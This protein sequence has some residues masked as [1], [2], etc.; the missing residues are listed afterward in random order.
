[1]ADHSTSK[2]SISN[3]AFSYLDQ[4]HDAVF[5]IGEDMRLRLVN[6]TLAQWMNEKHLTPGGSVLS[7][8]IG[9]SKSIDLFVHKCE[10][11]FTGTPVRFEC[12]IRPQ[13]SMPRWTEISLNRVTLNH[14]DMEIIAIA[15]DIS[16]N[17][18]EIAKLRHQANHDE[19]TGL[20]N[21][22]EFTRKLSLLASNPQTGHTLLYL[23]L[24]QFKIINDTCGHHAGDELLGRLARL[25]A[26]TLNGN[27]ILSRIGS[28]EFAILLEGI[29]LEN[30]QKIAK[31]VRDAVAGFRFHWEEKY[32]DMSISIGVASIKVD[33]E[34]VDCVLSAADAACHVAK[35]KGRNQIHVYSDSTECASL[36]R[37]TAWISRITEA[38]ENN[39]FRLFYQNILPIGSEYGCFNHREILLRMIDTDGREIT[40]GEFVPAAEKYHLMPL[41]DRWVI[42]TLFFRNAALWR[43]ASV[44]LENCEKDAMP[45]C[46]INISG[47]SLN[48]DYFPI[49]LRDQLN[50][51]Q[52]PPQA[53]CF[54]ITETVAI[55]NLDK[56]SSLIKEL[57]TLGF[58]F[59]LDDFGSGMSSF[60][61]LKSLPVD[62]LKIDGSLVKNLDNDKT[63]FCMVEAINKIAQE[64]GI[65]TIAEFV[66]NRSI[67]EKLQSIGVNFAQGYSI[68]EPE[69]LH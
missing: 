35:N 64:M 69:H 59:S 56:V 3:P 66:G 43:S 53:V 60:A 37:E 27:G 16:A 57:K 23:D 63:D 61:Y 32:F 8:L 36:K 42:R 40:P 51:Y 45:L 44:L 5:V 52:I 26:D 20:L 38:F 62:F 7:S 54:E 34:G 9:L 24:D 2:A 22:R 28:D 11:A 18:N 4:A 49:F 68:H 15:R 67:F 14:P 30:A 48:D 58:R 6:A 29:S 21:R 31:S 25:L 19:L 12:L 55:N 47:S 13:N 41:I 33:N 1:M 65:K 17:R 46:S 39:R 10:I 50:L